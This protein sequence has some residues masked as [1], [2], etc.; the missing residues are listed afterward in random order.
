MS[1]CART[2]RLGLHYLFSA[3]RNPPFNPLIEAHAV[4][5]FALFTPEATPSRPYLITSG[6]RVL[7]SC[8][9][10]LLP[11]PKVMLAWLRSLFAPQTPA[12][13]LSQAPAEPTPSERAPST[14]PANQWGRVGADLKP[15][16]SCGCMTQG[17][18]AINAQTGELVPGV[19]YVC[20]KCMESG[21]V[22]PM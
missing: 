13:D 8:P 17:H 19:F 21:N 9:C 7:H 20:D 14:R 4:G 11:Y 6:P 5:R 2:R 22:G 10:L 18:R 3:Q 1:G 12:V 15:C 16:T